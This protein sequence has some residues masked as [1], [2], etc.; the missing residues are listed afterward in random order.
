VLV[1]A[2]PEPDQHTERKDK[3]GDESWE[4]RDNQEESKDF[5]IILVWTHV[6][7]MV[8]VAFGVFGGFGRVVVE[9][10][11]SVEGRGYL[12]LNVQRCLVVLRSLIRRDA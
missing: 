12:C 7:C 10:G 8:A 1:Q 6:S 5:E 2:I 11:E 3:S 4:Y 9:S